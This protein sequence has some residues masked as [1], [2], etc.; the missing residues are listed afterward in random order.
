MVVR[1][2]MTE[3]DKR[4][5]AVAELLSTEATYVSDMKVCLWRVQWSLLWHLV[6]RCGVLDG[7]GSRSTVVC[8]GIYDEHGNEYNEY[9]EYNCTINSM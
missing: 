6:W 4:D 5:A 3:R 7:N 8:S 1:P 2:S 9:N